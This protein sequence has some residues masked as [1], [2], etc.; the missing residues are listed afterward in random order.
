MAI[1][2]GIVNLPELTGV[3]ALRIT[4]SQQAVVTETLNGCRPKLKLYLFCMYQNIVF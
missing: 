4:K 3:V 2:A 1:S